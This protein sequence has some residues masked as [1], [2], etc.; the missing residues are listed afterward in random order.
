M[1]IVPSRIWSERLARLNVDGKGRELSSDWMARRLPELSFGTLVMALTTNN[2]YPDFSVRW[3][4]QPERFRNLWAG[5]K[6]PYPDAA[7]FHDIWPG[8]GGGAYRRRFEAVLHFVNEIQNI[9][10]RLATKEVFCQAPLEFWLAGTSSTGKHHQPAQNY[11]GGNMLHVVEMSALVD[12]FIRMF[13]IFSSDKRSKRVH[14]D[15]MDCVLAAVLT[16]DCWKGYSYTSWWKYTTPHH[17]ILSAMAWEAVVPKHGLKH[18]TL[19]GNNSVSVVDAILAGTY[20]HSGLWTPETPAGLDINDPYWLSKW[21]G[22][23]TDLRDMAWL[24]HILDM[25]SAA[26][27]TIINLGGILDE[28][29][30]F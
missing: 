1:L 23:S 18:I 21:M 5:R 25:I 20:G 24:C 2:L 11:M 17:P 28:S 12:H 19:P 27:R 29:D 26:R 4:D 8:W 15:W 6:E 7:H 9:D 30:T 14:S 13:P 16:H 10:I 22:G 3:G